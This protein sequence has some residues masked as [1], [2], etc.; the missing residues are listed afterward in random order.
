MKTLELTICEL[1]HL[2]NA[3]SIVLS[4]AK[5][6]LSTLACVKLSES[7]ID[8]FSELIKKIEFVRGF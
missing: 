3:L 6:G 7:E 8:S 1:T 5:K 4:Y 2:H